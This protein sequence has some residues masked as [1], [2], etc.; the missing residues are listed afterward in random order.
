M[1]KCGKPL[2]FFGKWAGWTGRTIFVKIRPVGADELTG[3]G[4][5]VPTDGSEVSPAVA[6]FSV[7]RTEL[8]AAQRLD[9]E[10]REVILYL[11]KV[12]TTTF[13]TQARK[14]GKKL[15]S[16]AM[17]FKMAPDGVL[18][19]KTEEESL[20]LPVVPNVQYEGSSALADRPKTM[21]WKHLLLASVHNTATG[22]HMRASEMQ[23]ELESLVS[24]NPPEK[25]RHDCELWTARC[26]HCVGQYKRPLGTVGSPVTEYRPCM[27]AQLDLMEVRPHGEQGETHVLTFVC[28]ATRYSFFRAIIGRETVTIAE[29]LLDCILDMGVVPLV[30][31]SD[32]EFLTL[33]IEELTTLLGSSQIF[34]NALR[35]QTQ[36][37]VERGHR[38]M[39]S[40]LAILI[41]SLARAV[42][43]K[44]P[45]YIRW[46]EARMRHKTVLN[47]NGMHVTPYQVVHGFAGSS[48]LR[49]SF[50]AL[51]EIPEAVVHT[52][53]L[54]GIVQ[55]SAFLSQ[56]LAES[57]EEKAEKS[58]REF[59]TTHQVNVEEGELVLLL[60][61]FY[62]RGAG[63]I[64]PQNDGPFVVA[65][66][67]SNTSVKLADCLTGELVQGGKLISTARLIK[68]AYPPEFAK[69]DLEE[70]ATTDLAVGDFIAV[71]T[72]IDSKLRTVV[73][74]IQRLFQV[75]SQAEVQLYEIPSTDRFGPWT[76][77]IWVP[78][79]GY[80][81]ISFTEIIC[82]VELQNG[83]LTARS[84]EVLHQ[85]GVP[86]EAAGKEKA[87]K[88]RQLQLLKESPEDEQL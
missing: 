16:K 82:K 2:N 61:P 68:F 76:R 3:F 24:W 41:E 62:E 39:R 55:E 13:L 84:L 26:K 70:S 83:A 49:S 37:I 38:E 58:R 73:A 15:R 77:R 86:I 33:V 4:G 21:T 6:N 18:L 1:E 10:L 64:L 54:S 65:K 51:K 34:S 85:N 88:T 60:K 56:A 43:R 45:K 48:A 30:I 67:V 57:H 29:A 44:W 28:V 59:E 46:L 87:L 22:V 23:V 42:P 27:R 5:R 63:L 81:Q 52:E 14:D 31:Q 75:G 35:P 7:L 12:P 32:L 40:T 78:K 8:A 53:W 36:G 74:K 79:P 25:L 17:H 71:E 80:E 9:P 69:A 11:Q 20:E 50:A 72:L 19:A 66:K 47:V